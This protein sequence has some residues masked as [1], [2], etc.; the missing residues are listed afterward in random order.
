[1]KRL[2]FILFA[3]IGVSQA[4]TIQY[5]G[6]PTTTVI[7]RGN[8]RTDSIFYL[9]K[10]TKAPT[11]TAAIRYQISDS[12]L[13]V[14]TGS[15]WVKAGGSGTISGSGLTGYIP[16]FTTTTNLDTTR[17]YHSAGRFAIGS[18]TVS[19]GVFNV[20]SGQSYFDTSLKVGS[21]TLLADEGKNE[22]YINTTTDAGAYALQVSGNIYANSGINIEASQ[23]F[24]LLTDQTNGQINKIET[25]DSALYFMADT[26]NAKANTRL[27]FGID[28]SVSMYINTQEELII[29]TEN[30]DRGDFKLQ[31]INGSARID[32]DIEVQA[33]ARLATIS[34]AVS[35]GTT[36]TTGVL[37]VS[38]SSVNTVFDSKT[39]TDARIEYHRAG[40][41]RSLFNWDS[42]VAGFQQESGVNFYI[43]GSETLIGTQTD[44]GAYA[45]QVSGAIYNTTTITTGAPTGGS[46]T[47]WRLG[48]AATVSPTSP[49]RTLR[50]EVGGTV[51]Y[52]AAKTT[53][54]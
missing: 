39:A 46:V 47:A 12:S 5:I 2:I 22:V 40:S 53:N 41:R 9:P 3:I 45:L 43:T 13:Y 16:E 38:K 20:Y 31:V 18:T 33:N 7:S 44:A 49:N 8:F 17:L 10:R 37:N 24:L 15:Q 26:A 14:W 25:R 6:A 32:N 42:N 23:S 11:D 1:M 28:N 51:Y 34:G 19:N 48:E 21:Q 36:S 30:D 52:I 4:Q 27:I 50:V 54:D 29:N 35:I